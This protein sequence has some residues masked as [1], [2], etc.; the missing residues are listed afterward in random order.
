LLRVRALCQAF[1]GNSRG[2]GLIEVLIALAILGVVAVAF[3]TAL[4]TASTAL[5]LADE[6]TTA[7]SLARSQLESVKDQPYNPTPPQASY[8][9]P[10]GGIRPGYSIWSL[11]YQGYE[12]FPQID[13]SYTN[14]TDIIGVAWDSANCR[15]ALVDTGLQAVTVII[16]HEGTDGPIL[17]TT[18]YKRQS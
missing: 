8:G 5:I 9:A 10:I 11:E 12:N 4:T 2:F 7:E 16:Y 18:A 14:S 1:G 3:L 15:P 13:Y 17:T 6:R